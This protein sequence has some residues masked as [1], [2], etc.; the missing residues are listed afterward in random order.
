MKAIWNYKLKKVGQTVLQMPQG[1]K[2]LCM[3]L[4]YGE[5]VIW[6]LVDIERPLVWRLFRFYATGAPID[7]NI[8]PENYIGTCQ[9]KGGDLVFHL[10]GQLEGD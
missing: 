10:F 3:Q 7:P 9:V 1:A 4:Q 8:T 2:V 5:P 6:A